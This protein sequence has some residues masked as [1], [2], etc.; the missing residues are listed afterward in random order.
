MQKRV[1]VKIESMAYK[2]YGVA[3]VDH[4][5]LFVPFSV[6]GDEAWAEIVEEKKDY[7]IARIETLI[8]PSPWRTLPE[9]PYFG[10]CGGCQWQHIDYSVHGELKK[11]ILIDILKRMGGQKEIPPMTV[12]PSPKSYGYRIRVQLK[13]EGKALGYYQERSHHIV[14]I[15]HCPIAHPL[16]NQLILLLRERLPFL[17]QFEEVEISV[18]PEEK[19]G[20]LLLHPLSFAKEMRTFAR[21]LLQD[22]SILKG[23]TISGKG[24][25]TSIGN[26]SLTFSVSL[27]RAGEKKGWSLRASPESFFQVNVEQ[28]Q[29]LLQTVLR[30]GEVNEGESVLDLYAGI[31]NFTLPL[32]LG[33]KEV[34]GIEENGK[35]VEDARFN[36]ERNGI[37]QCRMKRGRVEEILKNWNAK[38]PDLVVLDPPRSG[39]KEGVNQIIGLK[40]KRIVYVSCDPTTFSRDLRLL[41]E[42]GYSLQEVS[43]IDMFP[44][45]YH[46]EVVALLKSLY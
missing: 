6:T 44:Q 38:E 8:K 43:L 19:K 29:A 30:F 34:L 45:T 14:D 37:T 23:V 22:H 46:M 20:V 33:A 21:D 31:G 41:S 24:R 2:G 39:G 18:S 42:K 27:D 16:V 40:P 13:T 11:N 4:K 17:S 9:C 15:E 35:A 36:I 28:N 32:A 7:G 1:Q 10:V 3:R 26:P 5:V 12:I 25:F